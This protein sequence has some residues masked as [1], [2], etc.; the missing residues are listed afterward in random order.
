MSLIN[1]LIKIVLSFKDVRKLESLY[2]TVDDVD[3][4]VG[5]LLEKL[6]PDAMVGFTARCLI[7]D[8]FHRARFGDR[9]FFD[10]REQPGSFSRGNVDD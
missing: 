8:V 10:V 3:L 1:Y 7:G 5:S 6:C 2:L 9:F 4:H